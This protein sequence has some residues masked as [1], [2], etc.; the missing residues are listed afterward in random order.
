MDSGQMQKIGQIKIRRRFIVLL[1][2]FGAAAL[3]CRWW[4]NARFEALK[5]NIRDLYSAMVQCDRVTLGMSRDEIEG[6]LGHPVKESAVVLPSG[7]KGIQLIFSTAAHLPRWPAVVIAESSRR[8]VRVECDARHGLIATEAQE[9]AF[10]QS[11]LY[12]TA[13]RRTV[14]P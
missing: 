2:F 8:A 6:I 9:A 14:A 10:F 11:S 13:P 4:I 1:V 5:S 7:R 12:G 3:F